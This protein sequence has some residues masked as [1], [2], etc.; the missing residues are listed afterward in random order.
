M[1][2]IS[3]LTESFLHHVSHVRMFFEYLT[4]P[5]AAVPEPDVRLVIGAKRV[6]YGREKARI[7]MSEYHLVAHYV[8]LLA[9]HGHLELAEFV[10]RADHVHIVVQID[11]AVLTQN[12]HAPNVRPTFRLKFIKKQQPSTLRKTNFVLS[13]VL[14]PLDLLIVNGAI[15]GYAMQADHFAHILVG[16]RFVPVVASERA[17]LAVYDDA[18][19]P[20]VHVDREQADHLVKAQ[21]GLV[22]EE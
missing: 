22:H 8:A 9:A 6:E 20:M 13:H 11:A 17:V 12:D 7:P 3:S 4:G 15:D 10:K 1:H 18:I 19:G 16:E 21:R 14:E 2:Y 5:L